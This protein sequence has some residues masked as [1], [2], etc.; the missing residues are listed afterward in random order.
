MM[1]WDLFWDFSAYIPT[2]NIYVVPY[3]RAGWSMR[4]EDADGPGRCREGPR[5]GNQSPF[6]VSVVDE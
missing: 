6:H 2:F 4:A 5:V 3:T 1:F